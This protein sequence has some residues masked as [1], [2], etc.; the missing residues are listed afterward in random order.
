MTASYC[1]K[2]DPDKSEGQKVWGSFPV[3]I[4]P[5]A[6]GFPG[7]L[8]R[9]NFIS[10]SAAKFTP[11]ATRPIP[12]TAIPS[13]GCPVPFP[14]PAPRSATANSSSAWA[15]AISSTL[16]PT[17][18]ANKQKEIQDAELGKKSLPEVQKDIDAAL[19][20]LPDAG[21]LWCIDLKTHNV[22]WKFDIGQTV[23][24]H[25]RHR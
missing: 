24:E 16:P 19:K 4:I 13:G 20:E 15:S 18:R 7:H 11:C 17:L 1:F 10:A 3:R 12:K 2:L 6:R 21:Q 25:T 8:L 23:L 5:I 22:D 14:P 9:E